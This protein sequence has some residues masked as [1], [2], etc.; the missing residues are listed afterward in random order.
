MV[1]AAAGSALVAASFTKEGMAVKTRT[2]RVVR[3]FIYER[4]GLSVGE[5]IEV[6]D[7]FAREVVASNKAV[8][9]D[10]PVP[11]AVAP[12]PAPEPTPEPEVDEN[13][14]PEKPAPFKLRGGYGKKEEKHAR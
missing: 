14:E 7:G 10:P 1:L 4:K 13:K 3:A 12:E 11:A 2:I 8:F 6:P 5:V 9:A